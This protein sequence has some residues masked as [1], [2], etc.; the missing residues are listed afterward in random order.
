VPL[1]ITWHWP[2]FV[3]WCVAVAIA[4]LDQLYVRRGMRRFYGRSCRGWAWR[5]KFPDANKE[6]IR[7]FLG[8]FVDAF[9]LRRKPRVAFGPDDRIMDVYRALYPIEGFPD[10]LELETFDMRLEEQY[11]VKLVDFYRPDLTLGEVFGRIKP[12]PH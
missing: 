7:A 1:A 6:D 5:R 9:A 4:I 2:S 3:F 8:L 10:A 12:T 11:G